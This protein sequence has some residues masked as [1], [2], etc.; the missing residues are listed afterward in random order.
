MLE[1]LHQIAEL[2]LR[3]NQAPEENLAPEGLPLLFQE[4]PG[5][6]EKGAGLGLFEIRRQVKKLNFEFEP[7]GEDFMLVMRADI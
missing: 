7:D 1:D 5:G 6:S 3:P 2:R 4:E